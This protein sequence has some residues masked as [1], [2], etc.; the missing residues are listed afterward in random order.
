MRMNEPL[1]AAVVHRISDDSSPMNIPGRERLT[2][3]V[4]LLGEPPLWGWEILDS[5]AGTLVES[6]WAMEW[7]G[8]GSSREAL[9]AGLLRLTDLTRG[10]RGAV[11]DR[12]REPSPAKSR[13]LMVI[14]RDAAEL[15]ASLKK[16]F[17]DAEGI[18]VVLDRRFGERR[19]RNA[20]VPLDRRQGERRSRPPLKGTDDNPK[21]RVHRPETPAGQP[22]PGL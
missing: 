6:S 9:R 2:V 1:T 15:Y 8:Y 12:R 18:D 20:P 7:T 11:L 21:F 14:A 17:A 16:T 5:E 13:H 4:H 10:A 3:K 19:Q 22:R